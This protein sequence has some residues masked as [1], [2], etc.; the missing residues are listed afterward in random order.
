M[1]NHR[2]R[3]L[4]KLV[5]KGSFAIQISG[6]EIKTKSIAERDDPVRFFQQEINPEANFMNGSHMRKVML[7]T[8]PEI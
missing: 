5:K 7:S 8:N 1:A 3:S 2:C 4:E 6:N